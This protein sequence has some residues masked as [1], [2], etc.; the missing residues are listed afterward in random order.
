MRRA[1]AIGSV[2]VALTALLGLPTAMGAP[3]QLDPATA[4][5]HMLR[6][7]DVTPALGLQGPL[8]R[9]IVEGD[10]LAPLLCNL[11]NQREV[12]APTSQEKVAVGLTQQDLSSV[13][14]D[15]FQYASASAARSAFTRLAT[16]AR[17]CDERNALPVN[18]VQVLTNGA[19]PVQFKGVP[20]VWTREVNATRG[21]NGV[22]DYDSY[23][24]S[25]LVGDAIQQVT[26]TTLGAGR[27]ADVQRSSVDTLALKLAKRW[28]RST[29]G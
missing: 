10:R 21:A 24:V 27:A 5:R 15:L 13:Q 25:L 9:D 29:S 22:V 1:L 12:V 11:A 14:Q 8:V 7:S 16:R 19:A 3:A 18:H 26:L 4:P 20:G 2:T 6:A 28:V 17:Q 23:T